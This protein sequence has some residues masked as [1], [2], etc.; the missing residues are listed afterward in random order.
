MPQ[1]ARIGDPISHVG[2]P[3]TPVPPTGNVGLSPVQPPPVPGRPPTP[4]MGVPSVRIGGRAAAVIGT[5]CRC[6]VPPQHLVINPNVLLPSPPTPRGLVLIGGFPAARTGDKTAC[7][8]F[9]SIG[10]PT[11]WIGGRP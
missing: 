9:V 1:A 10:C 3:L 8:G 7:G 4:M 6:N 5:A 11:V 2:V